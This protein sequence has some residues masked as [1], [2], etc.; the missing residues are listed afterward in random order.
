MPRQNTFESNDQTF[1]ICGKKINFF[2]CVIPSEFH[3]SN[4]LRSCKINFGSNQLVSVAATQYAAVVR[5]IRLMAIKK[6]EV[7]S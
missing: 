1:A 6:Q 7:S 3:T 2:V 4:L 5:L